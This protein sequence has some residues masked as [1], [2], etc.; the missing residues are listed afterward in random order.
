MLGLTAVGSTCQRELLVA[1]AIR[2]ESARLDERH[3]LKRFGARA[4]PCYE[5]GIMC[6]SDEPVARV[7]YCR[8]HSMFRLDRVSPGNDYIQLV[9]NHIAER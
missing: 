7:Y 9:N 5:L 3:C 1:P 4:P 6:C 2:I 8:M